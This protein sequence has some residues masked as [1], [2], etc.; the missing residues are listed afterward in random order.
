MIQLSAEKNRLVAEN[1]E[2][3]T[4][5]SVGVNWV[6]F[7]FD[8]NWDG[9][10]RTAVFRCG[11]TSVS[12]ALDDAN[13]CAIPW[14]VLTTPNWGLQVGVYGTQGEDVVLPTVWA[15]LGTVREGASVSQEAAEHTPDV[16]Q[17]V[18]ADV[19]D[20]GG[21]ETTDKSSLVAAINE[22]RAFAADDFK[23]DDT[24]SYK[25]GALG[26]NCATAVEEDN[27]LPVTA[28]AVYTQVGNINVLLQTI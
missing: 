11:E 13:T 20:L 23:L 18:L 9:F 2:P 14:E 6:Q 22:V 4:S 17:K 10:T 25:D 24:L 16:F 27:T 28:A 3:I 19:G 26:V 8:E 7:T 5:G 21:L 15:Y 12:M 1:A